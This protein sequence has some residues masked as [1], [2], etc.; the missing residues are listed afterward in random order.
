MIAACPECETRYRVPQRS[1]LGRSPSFRCSRCEHVF[2]LDDAVEGPVELDESDLPAEAAEEPDDDYEPV[3]EE[4]AEAMGDEQDE[5]KQ[6]RRRSRG[7]KVEHDEEPSGQSAA[8]FALRAMLG[9][10]LGYGVFSIYL[11]THPANLRSVLGRVPIIGASFTDPQ[12][13]PDQ[14]Q[15]TGVKGEYRQVQGSAVVFVVS[16]VAIN[17]AP[18]AVRG[19]QIKARATGARE[20]SVQ[21]YCGTQP[22]DVE[23][24][25]VPELQMLQSLERPPAGWTLG[26]GQQTPFLL[27][28]ASPPP[29]LREFSAE[30]TAVQRTR[31]DDP[32][33]A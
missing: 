29:A 10:T 20:D 16:G 24:Y 17:N 32:Q 4:E 30:V 8:Q 7:A 27:V 14:I 2:A 11:Y 25:S 33:G 3:M 31:S 22:H 19:L 15:L 18:V 28:F 13:G 21:V 12:L 23:R 1:K 26:P 9:V 6:T 5:P